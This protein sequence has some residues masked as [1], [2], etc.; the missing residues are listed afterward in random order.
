MLE[1]E[2]KGKGTTLWQLCKASFNLIQTYSYQIPGNETKTKVWEN[3]ILGQP[4]LSSLPGMN[5]LAE[6]TRS[7]G[8]H[9]LHDLSL[10]NQKGIWE[11]WKDLHPPPHLNEAK[12]LLMDSLQG[13]SPINKT[14]KD[15]ISW[16]KSGQYMVNEG[17]KILSTEPTAIQ[18]TWKKVWQT[19][20]IP[21]VN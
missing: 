5:D 20:N 13:M 8:L 1:G 16:G 17:Y 15:S 3:I 6:W 12:N 18:R 7:E 4:P 21:K 14:K 9:S 10:W 2:W 11:G 19:D